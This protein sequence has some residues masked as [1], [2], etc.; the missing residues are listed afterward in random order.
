MNTWS[1]LLYLLGTLPLGFS[2]SL[3]SFYFHAAVVLGKFPSYGHPDP[4]EL[5][6]Y[7]VY[8]PVVYFTGSVWMYSF[9]FWL[10]LVI[11]YLLHGNR[12]I[13]WKPIVIGTFCQISVVSMF[14]SGILMWFV[15]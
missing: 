14:V 7:W 13:K 12:P 5:S 6:F 8:A 9:V 3:M 11:V 2:I 1:L 15:D 4:K 10:L